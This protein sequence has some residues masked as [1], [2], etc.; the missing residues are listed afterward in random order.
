MPHINGLSHP[1]DPDG[2]SYT[3]S[4][5][6]LATTSIGAGVVAGTLAAVDAASGPT[7]DALS[8]HAVVAAPAL[9]GIPIP[10]FAALAFLTEGSLDFWIFIFS[11]VSVALA[12]TN[13]Y[14]GFWLKRRESVAHATVF[15]QI[16]AELHELDTEL[17]ELKEKVEAAGKESPKVE[18]PTVGPLDRTPIREE[19]ARP[20]AFPIRKT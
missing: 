12:S 7:L 14:L 4:N 10:S 1:Q 3:Q 2:A 5:I 9:A 17:H 13:L 16:D 6:T 20:G 15:E 8:A 11:F 18:P 19:E